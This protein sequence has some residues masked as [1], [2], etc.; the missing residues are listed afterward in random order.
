MSQPPAAGVGTRAGTEAEAEIREAQAVQQLLEALE[1]SDC[2]AILEATGEEALSA[3]EIADDC[4]MPLSTTYR[5]VEQLT[6]AGLLE[7]QVRIARSGKH[8]NEYRLGVEDIRVSVDAA[9]GV[10]L[11]VS[12]REC[13]DSRVGA[14][15]GAD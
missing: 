9:D 6:E 12:R 2:R 14:V 5:K 13:G 7:E 15:A 8:T 4:A 11:R 1:D 3:Q 10:E